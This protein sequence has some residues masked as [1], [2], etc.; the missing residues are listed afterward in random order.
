MDEHFRSLVK[1]ELI[2]SQLQDHSIANAKAHKNNV[3]LIIVFLLLIT[4]LFISLI[5]LVFDPD[6]TKRPIKIILTVLLSIL[7]LILLYFLLSMW[8][9]IPSANGGT[10]HT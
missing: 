2:T 8:K 7:G 3:L 5:W 4:V 10:C 1:Q 6:D 9:C